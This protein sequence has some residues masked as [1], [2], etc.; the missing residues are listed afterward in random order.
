MKKKK[1][2]IFFRNSQNL[3]NRKP[4]KVD[5]KSIRRTKTPKSTENHQNAPVNWN[6]TVNIVPVPV[7]FDKTVSDRFPVD[8]LEK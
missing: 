1:T 4:R 2:P 8:F 5:K 7:L 3:P 6:K